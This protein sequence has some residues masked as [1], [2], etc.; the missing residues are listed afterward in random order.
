MGIADA[1]AAQYRAAIRRLFPQGA[2]W[3]AQ[4]ADAGSDISLFVEA[5]LGE[6]VRFRKR[7]GALQGESVPESAD[8]TIGDW[9]RVCL[10]Y[11]DNGP[12]PAARRERLKSGLGLSLNKT[13]L[14]KTAAG[15]GFSIRGITFPYRPGFFGFSRFGQRTGG[16]ACFS[17]LLITV[18]REGLYPYCYNVIKND[19]PRKGAGRMRLGTDRLPYMPA[20]R[21]EG[22]VSMESLASNRVIREKKLFSGFETAT[23]EKL[24]ANQIPVFRY[25]GV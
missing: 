12:D 19:M 14:E 3:D 1:G 16:P 20:R 22:S 15:Y 9:E 13:V 25:E 18:E 5:K 17:V 2:Y 10:G 7:M 24:L 21:Q 8:E 4:F 6:L 23:G 11:T